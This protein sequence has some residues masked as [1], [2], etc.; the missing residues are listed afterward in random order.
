MG[1]KPEDAKYFIVLFV[2]RER[3]RDIFNTLKWDKV[4]DADENEI[5]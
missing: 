4:R 1:Q 5:D 3:G 2:M